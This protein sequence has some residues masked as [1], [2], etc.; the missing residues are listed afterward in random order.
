MSDKNIYY[1]GSREPLP[2]QR[3]LRAGPLSL[4]YEQ[5]DLRY[6][7]IG[8]REIIRRVYVAIRDRNWGTILP[9]LSNVQIQASED[10]FEITYDVQNKRGEIDFTWKGM[11][12]G[13]AQ[14]TITF[15]MDG[16]AQSTFW[17]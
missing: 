5:G 9:V 11:I 3:H 17:R 6:I 2:E 14:G 13:D 15:S 8:D 4:V 12:S 7:K 16:E 10:S 1:Y